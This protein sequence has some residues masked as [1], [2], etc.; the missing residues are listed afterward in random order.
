MRVKITVTLECGH[1]L[2]YWDSISEKYPFECQEC[3]YVCYGLEKYP[4]E[5]DTCVVDDAP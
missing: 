4:W 1:T 2:T 5:L 3:D